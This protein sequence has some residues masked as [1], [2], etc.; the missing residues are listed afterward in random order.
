MG[1]EDRLGTIKG[2]GKEKEYSPGGHELNAARLDGLRLI[3]R[4][5]LKTLQITIKTI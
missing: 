2:G 3:A 1:K 5:G 4:H